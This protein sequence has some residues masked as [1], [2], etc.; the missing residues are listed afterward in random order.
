MYT[1]LWL[2]F[3]LRKHNWRSNVRASTGSIPHGSSAQSSDKS[4]G[5]S[6][7]FKRNVKIDAVFVRDRYSSHRRHVKLSR[8]TE[9]SKGHKEV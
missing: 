8:I 1:N 7:C 6:S 9:I 3:N 4:G 2:C 5:V